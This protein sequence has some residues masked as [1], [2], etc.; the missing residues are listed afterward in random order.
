MS[1]LGMVCCS[2]SALELTCIRSPSPATLREIKSGQ[3]CPSLTESK[4]ETAKML[5]A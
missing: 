4:K 2:P 5:A 3:A 1:N